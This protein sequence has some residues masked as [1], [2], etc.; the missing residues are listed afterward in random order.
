MF[1]TLM[2]LSG[3]LEQQNSISN[4]LIASTTSRS[5]SSNK[6]QHVKTLTYCNQTNW[7]FNEFLLFWDTFTDNN[8]STSCSMYAK[9]FQKR[10]LNLSRHL[11]I[12]FPLQ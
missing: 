10:L 2:L 8:T 4:R 1:I 11:K 7:M 12:N 9:N 6:L 3:I 5:S